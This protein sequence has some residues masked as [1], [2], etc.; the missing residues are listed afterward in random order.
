M[1]AVELFEVELEGVRWILSL[2]MSVSVRGFECLLETS[3]FVAERC[4]ALVATFTVNTSEGRMGGGREGGGLEFKLCFLSLLLTFPTS[5]SGVS[6]V[7]V[8]GSISILAGVGR[9]ENMELMS[10]WGS[11]VTTR[12][13]C[14]SSS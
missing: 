14:G 12:S 11:S 1:S 10:C 8:I 3:V 13:A 7:L 6:G 2:P 4:A 9:L 5:R